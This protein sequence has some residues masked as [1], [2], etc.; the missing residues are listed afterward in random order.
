MEK[1]Q[2]VK[3][4]PAIAF[5]VPRKVTP[6]HITGASD[7]DVSRQ[8]EEQKRIKALE[9]EHRY[10]TYLDILLGKP[11][12]NWHYYHALLGLGSIILSNVLCC[13]I[14]FVPMHNVIEEPFYWY[15]TLI[16][17]PI[18]FFSSCAAYMLLNCCY[19]MNIDQIKSFKNFVIFYVFL[20]L[21]AMTVGISGK[22]IWT[23][24]L[25]FPHPMPFYGMIIAYMVIV[26]SFVGLWFLYP[27]NWRKNKEIWKRFKF[28]MW[29]IV[30]NLAITMIYNNYTKA[31]TTVPIDY[32]GGWALFLIPV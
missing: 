11:D 24:A 16:Q 13:V 30:A 15:E 18:G 28:F 20:V 8:I 1:G 5:G 9:E 17:A 29:S 25:G 14:T 10:N 7:W 6:L 3:V 27:K 23:E 2:I 21:V 31:F 26:M 32:Q 12:D 19:W 22:M 4:S